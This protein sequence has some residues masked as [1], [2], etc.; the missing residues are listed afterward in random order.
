MHHEHE[1]DSTPPD[2][3]RG[4]EVRDFSTRV[5]VVF[6]ASLVA[7]AVAVF[8]AIWLVFLYF[9]S[10]ADRAYPREY[11]VAQVGAPAQPPAPRLQTRPREE[12]EQ[13]RAEEDRMLNSYGWVDA[14]AGVVHIPVEQAMRMTLEQGLA[15]RAAEGAAAPAAPASRASSGRV[16]APSG[17]QP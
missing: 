15:S 12:L 4:H 6:G 10:V 5:V 13:M 2:V 16:L 14:S 17:R 3:S 9:G 11:P 1:I 8:A 7:G